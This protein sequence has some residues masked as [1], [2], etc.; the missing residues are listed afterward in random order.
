[1]ELQNDQAK[2]EIAR[3]KLDKFRCCFITCLVASIVL[4]VTS[5]FMPF[6]VDNGVVYMAK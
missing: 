1:M 2:K 4:I 5:A 3:K 6:L